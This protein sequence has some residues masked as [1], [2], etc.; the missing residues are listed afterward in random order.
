MPLGNRQQ[1]AAEDFRGIGAEAQAKGDG[2]GRERVEGQIVDA[3]NLTDAPHQA[4][5]AEIDQQY[6]EQ[7]GYATNDGRIGAAE[8]AQGDIG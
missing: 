6:P 8:P 5:G 1:R 2:A 7:L 4:D 3:E